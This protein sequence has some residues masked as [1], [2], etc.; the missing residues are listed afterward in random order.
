MLNPNK[1]GFVLLIAAFTLAAQTAPPPPEPGSIEGIVTNSL[2]GAPIAHAHV[3]LQGGQDPNTVYGAQTNGQ[4]KFS[5]LQVPPS[6]YG[7]SVEKPGYY[8]AA[9]RMRP[10]TVNLGKG[11]KK[12]DLKLAMLPGGVISGRVIDS[13]GDPVEHIAVSIES[14][15]QGLTDEEGRF[16]VGGVQAGRHRLMASPSSMPFPAEHRTDGTEETYHAATYYPGSLTKSGAQYVNVKPGAENS[17]IEIRLVKVPIVRVSGVVR[18][19]SDDMHASIQMMSGS[20]WGRRNGGQVQVG[21]DGTFSISRVDPGTYSISAM[22]FDNGRMT[23]SAP[24]SLEVAGSNV[25]NVELRLIPPGDLKGVVQWDGDPPQDP[26][27]TDPNKPPPPQRAGMIQI[28]NTSFS[29]M[30]GQ[31][32]F[33][34]Q[35]NAD[36]SFSLQNVTPGK[37][38]VRSMGRPGYVKSIQLGSQSI[39]GDLLDLTNG[40]T[41]E[42]LTITVS[43][44][45]AELSGTVLKGG[46]PAPNA[47]VA[48]YTDPLERTLLQVTMTGADGTYKFRGV[49]PGTYKLAVMDPDDPPGPMGMQ[50][51]PA[52]M[53]NAIE[54]SL[55]PSDKQV[56]ELKYPQRRE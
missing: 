24:V 34:A 10:P 26:A 47:S 8:S 37:Y 31:Q 46:D 35:L 51:D 21:K 54:I 2:T 29:M 7:L 9:N 56:R 5:I 3:M 40:A 44:A 1:T 43:A 11:E 49:R 14:G 36:N 42:P 33:A 12:G 23:M 50:I 45:T 32:Q 41:S 39:D 4:G 6:N 13:N 25:E 55:A 53:E 48:L 17:G 18:G 27:P 22:V 38:R 16:R 15:N 19:L 20:S 28:M 30:M 52:N